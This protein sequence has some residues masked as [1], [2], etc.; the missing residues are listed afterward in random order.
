MSAVILVR[1][2]G[3]VAGA[4]CDVAVS[5]RFY[6]LKQCCF[7]R[8]HCPGSQWLSSRS[9]SVVVV[10]WSVVCAVQLM[11]LLRTSRRVKTLRGKVTGI[12][13]STGQDSN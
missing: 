12:A 1:G 9:Y 4:Q 13:H 5:G 11:L 3:M 6:N 2:V 8:I 7:L 10:I